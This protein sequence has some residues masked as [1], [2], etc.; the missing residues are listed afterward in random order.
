M[1]IRKRKMRLMTNGAME[2]EYFRYN[3]FAENGES[4]SRFPQKFQFPFATFFLL[5]RKA[6]QKISV[7][8]AC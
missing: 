2:I 8:F 1:K 6:F 5:A 3:G 4:F 7:Q